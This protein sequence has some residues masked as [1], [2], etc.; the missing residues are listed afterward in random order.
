[1]VTFYAEG[2]VAKRKKNDPTNKYINAND[3]NNT[4]NNHTMDERVSSTPKELHT[5][6]APPQ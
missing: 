2:K 3:N 5:A 6:R 1:M 4:V